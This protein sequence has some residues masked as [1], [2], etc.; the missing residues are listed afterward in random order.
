MLSP[1]CDPT[2]EDVEYFQLVTQL[3]QAQAAA[4]VLDMRRQRSPAS[5]QP[6]TVDQMV[7]LYFDKIGTG[8]FNHL[9]HEIVETS[10]TPSTDR[11]ARPVPAVTAGDGAGWV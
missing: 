8:E 9:L 10:A 7:A 1:P 3:S 6:P 4:F 2:Q 5:G 11:P